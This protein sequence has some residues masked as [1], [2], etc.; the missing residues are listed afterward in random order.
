MTLILTCVTPHYVV[1][2]S[3]RRL[4]RAS[5]GQMVENPQNKT[6]FVCGY[7]TKVGALA[8][9]GIGLVPIRDE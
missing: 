2:V 9:V 6:P 3:D 1:Q 5:D 8:D 7:A 4:T